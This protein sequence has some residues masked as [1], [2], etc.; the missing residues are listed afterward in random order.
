M[1]VLIVGN[2]F[3]VS[4]RPIS[5]LSSHTRRYQP[6]LSTGLWKHVV[7]RALKIWGGPVLS[8]CWGKW[9]DG[10]SPPISTEL[11]S[12]LFWSLGQVLALE[13]KPFLCALPRQILCYLR[14]HSGPETPL[15]INSLALK[16]WSF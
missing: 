14:H 13:D 16:A 9:A 5:P 11:S 10:V 1:L 4:K 2:R 8:W 3:I 15:Q 7:D 6:G 12:G